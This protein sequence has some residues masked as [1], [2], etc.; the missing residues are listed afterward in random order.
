MT[1]SGRILCVDIGTSSLKAAL[2]D[3]DGREHA[4]V[5]VA[6]P[7]KAYIHGILPA[8]AWEDALSRALD[9]LFSR[10]QGPIPGSVADGVCISGN[11]PTLVPVTSDGETTPPLHWYDGRVVPLGSGPG[12]ASLFLPHA[13][14]FREHERELYEKTGQLFSAQEWLSFRLGADPVTV[15]PTAYEPYYW[16]AAQCSAAGLDIRKFPPFVPLGSII[17]RV[18]A[19][20][21]RRFSRGG[22]L[23]PGI[24]IIAGGPDFIMA[25]IGTGALRPGI[26]CDRAGS[27][28]GINVCSAFPIR[29]GELRIL[30][31]AEAG[32]WNISGIIPASGRLFEWYRT[33]TGQAE[34]GYE[35]LLEEITGTDS[36]SS[37]PA[38]A[39][40]FFPDGGVLGNRQSPSILF[41]AGLPGR[42]GL[43]RAVLEAM[44]FMV[45]AT[46]ETLTRHGFPVTEMRLSGG[47]SKSPRWNQLKADI[48]GCTLLVPEIHDGE[49]AG[50]AVLG[51][52][53]LGALAGTPTGPGLSEGSGLTEAAGAMIRIK[54]RYTPHPHVA[55]AYTKRYR[56]Y[57]ELRETMGQLISPS[58][59]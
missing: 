2:I 32:L 13:A 28:E 22:G 49:L 26:V 23:S 30:P 46:L 3:F 6:Y 1:D 37:C 36:D 48:T 35:D 29:T 52:L 12:P 10:E 55:P 44:G 45:R 33:L 59:E 17:G 4:F 5:R 42:A 56:G 47:Q 40:L 43:G 27:S 15:L 58:P 20:A 19:A 21:A 31:H 38:G 9:R 53:A 54:E 57:C 8:T 34:R 39:T 11:G 51:A 50:D 25:L 24:P 41:P 7:A 18:S 14:W 16:D